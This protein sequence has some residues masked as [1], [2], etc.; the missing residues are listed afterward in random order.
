MTAEAKTLSALRSRGNLQTRLAF[1]C[2]HTQLATERRLPWRELHFVNQ[3]VAFN[4]K[5]RMAC[6][7]YSQKQVPA[8][9]APRSRF[10]LASKPDPLPLVHAFRNFDLIT[11]HLVG[12]PAS[13]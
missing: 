9:T 6:Q 10:P 7:P 12:I 4:G 5:I 3:I 8:L 11:F 2:R 1:Q 13:E